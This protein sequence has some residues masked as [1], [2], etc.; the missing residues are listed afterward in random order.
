MSNQAH[1]ITDEAIE[2]A[3]VLARIERSRAF[4]D[5]LT[6]IKRFLGSASEPRVPANADCRVL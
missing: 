5:A 3:L 4:V 1:Q 2:N 6:S